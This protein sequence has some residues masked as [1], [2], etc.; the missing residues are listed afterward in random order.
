MMRD[1]PLY[2]ELPDP[3]AEEAQALIDKFKE[4]MR[5]VADEVLGEVYVNIVPH[6]ESDSWTNYR[7]AMMDGFRNY[8]NRKVQGQHE[9][10]EIRQEI[11]KEFRDDII[12]DLDQDN[13]DR[14]KELEEVIRILRIR[15]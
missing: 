4:Q 6:I 7:N 9:F 5:K 14:I 10:K 2:P 3:G 15:H 1:Y 11:Y 12:K 13:L 8:N